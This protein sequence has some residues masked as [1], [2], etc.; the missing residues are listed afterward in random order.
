MPVARLGPFPVIILKTWES[1]GAR[2]ASNNSTIRINSMPSNCQHKKRAKSG[3]EAFI[4]TFMLEATILWN[5]FDLSWCSFCLPIVTK[6]VQRSGISDF[7]ILTLYWLYCWISWFPQ[8]SRGPISLGIVFDWKFAPC[9]FLT[10]S[11]KCCS[12]FSVRFSHQS[13]FTAGHEEETLDTRHTSHS[14]RQLLAQLETSLPLIPQ[15]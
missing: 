9:R 2:V 15:I 13:H 3:E 8:L 5:S 1:P 7:I 4:K 10:F 11:F 12:L 6:S 14:H